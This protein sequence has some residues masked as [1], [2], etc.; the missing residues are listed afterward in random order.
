[1]IGIVIRRYFVYS[2][3]QC[4]HARTHAH[5][6]G[7]THARSTR[8]YR[9]SLFIIFILHKDVYFFSLLIVLLYWSSNTIRRFLYHSILLNRVQPISLLIIITLNQ[10]TKKNDWVHLSD[11]RK[12]RNTTGQTKARKKNGERGTDEAE[13]SRKKKEKVNSKKKKRIRLKIYIYMREDQE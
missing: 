10:V 1:M 8:T 11:S 3:L 6:H 9:V 12:K 7:R 4:V 13:E 2:I 5:I